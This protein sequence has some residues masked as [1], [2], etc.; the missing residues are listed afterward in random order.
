MPPPSHFP[1]IAVTPVWDPH[2]SSILFLHP[3]SS[4]FP[5]SLRQTAAAC[6]RRTAAAGG[7][8]QHRSSSAP[9]TVVCTKDSC[10]AALCPT[11][12]IKS[13]RRQ[14]IQVQS[15]ICFDDLQSRRCS[16][17][18]IRSLA[19]LFELAHDDDSHHAD[20]DHDDD[21][22]GAARKQQPAEAVDQLVAATTPA[23]CCSGDEEDVDQ[24]AAATTPASQLQMDYTRTSSGT[25]SQRRKPTQDTTQRRWRWPC[26]HRWSGNSAVAFVALAAI[27]GRLL[28][29]PPP[30]VTCCCCSPERDGE[31]RKEGMEEEDGAD[32]WV[33]HWS[34]GDGWKMRRRW[35]GSNFTKFQ[36]HSA[37]F[38]N[39]SDTFSKRHRNVFVETVSKAYRHFKRLNHK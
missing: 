9:F 8:R 32:V 37:D 27:V 3:L 30:P 38:V 29:L 14:E 15:L 23:S 7:R 26:R 5:I 10:S 19:L 39:S 16:L 22:G 4:P 28:L 33:P 35:H 36:W 20:D 17:L 21:E 25:T 24:L 31:G 34:D 13:H 1:S 18:I 11:P 2:V 6:G 12:K